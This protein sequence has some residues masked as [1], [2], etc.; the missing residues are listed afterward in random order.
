MRDEFDAAMNELSGLEWKRRGYFTINDVI[1]K[2]KYELLTQRLHDFVVQRQ[3]FIRNTEDVTVIKEEMVAFREDMKACREGLAKFRCSIEVSD[4]VNDQLDNEADEPNDFIIELHVELPFKVEKD[5]EEDKTTEKDGF[6]VTNKVTD[7]TG[8]YVDPFLFVAITIG[9][10]GDRWHNKIF[11]TPNG[12]GYKVCILNIDQTSINDIVAAFMI[13]L[14]SNPSSRLNAKC[15]YSTSSW[16][17]F[18]PPQENDVGANGIK[19]K[20]LDDHG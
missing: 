19:R 7:E 2:C 6:E 9:V 8:S 3:E 10:Q 4:D 13:I 20:K 5:K 12:H 15:S 17:N 1:L 18:I 16:L 14:P 11:D